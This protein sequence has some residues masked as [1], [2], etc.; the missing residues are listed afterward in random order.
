MSD[1]TAATWNVFH[2]TPRETL[3]PI[4]DQLEQLDVSLILGQEMA[5]AEHRAMLRHAGF[6]VFWHPRQYVVAWDPRVWTDVTPSAG[7]R[8]SNTAYWARGGDHG[9][10]SEAATS[11]LCDQLGRSL[12]VAS[13]HFPA[14][15]QHKDKPERRLQATRESFETLRRR[16]IESEA[17]ACLFGGDDNVDER[18]GGRFWDFL[19]RKPLIQVQAPSGTH[20]HRRI[21]D[22]RITKGLTPRRGH[23]IAVP[24]PDDHR[25][26]VR[27][28]DWS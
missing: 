19:L 12:N 1:F 10:Y 24:A 4:M 21:D 5:K 8:L 9:Q 17:R 2:D 6:E 20:G 25:V 22:F 3:E 7:L 18:H 26:H 23:V 11:L 27:S 13:Y 16:A 28:F 15:V 14:H